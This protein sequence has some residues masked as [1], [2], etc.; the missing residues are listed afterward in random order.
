MP[1]YNSYD[2]SKLDALHHV[3]N[4]QNIGKKVKEMRRI[5]TSS[6]ICSIYVV[7]NTNRHRHC[8]RVYV[9]VGA[10]AYLLAKVTWYGH[11]KLNQ[12]GWRVHSKAEAVIRVLSKA[13]I[14]SLY[15]NQKIMAVAR[16]DAATVAMTQWR[17]QV[18][19][20]TQDEHLRPVGLSSSHVALTSTGAHKETNGPECFTAWGGCRSLSGPGRHVVP[21]ALSCN[22]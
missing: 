6:W 3:W 13:N 8:I 22:T 21:W 20:G 10:Q 16:T 18:I 9:Y 4:S 17:L 15:Q 14:L 2:W 5:G 7:R 19:Q 1:R 12:G 11:R